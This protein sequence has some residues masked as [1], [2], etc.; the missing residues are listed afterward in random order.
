MLIEKYLAFKRKYVVRKRREYEYAINRFYAHLIDPFFTKLVYDLK[1][2]PNLVT[3]FTGLLG[4]GAGVS[5]FLQRWVL[6]A[7]LLQLHH[8]F[9]GADGNLARLTNRCTPFG[10][11]LDQISDQT[12]R[13]VL[14]LGLALGADLPVWLRIAL[15]LTIL[16]DLVVV[17]KYVLPFSRKNKLVRSKWKQWFL[18]RGIIPGFDIFSIF[19]IIS[20]SA[21]FGWLPQAILIIVI[22]KN[23]DW[24]YRVY[25]CIK[26]KSS[27]SKPSH[28]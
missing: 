19:F 17:H 20:I 26:T 15:P 18:D 3:V 8:F 10:A 7:V 9:D 1:L 16:V 4:I 11:K 25:E 21:I 5:F 27:A 14:F 23:L 22:L 12:V 13:W 24:L 2:T 28:L 6:G